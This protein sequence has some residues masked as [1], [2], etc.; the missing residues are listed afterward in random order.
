MTLTL[1]R[2]AAAP[3][4]HLDRGKGAARVGYLVNSV[5]MT[6]FLNGSL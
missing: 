2:M 6:I 3:V 4:F 1:S 5:L